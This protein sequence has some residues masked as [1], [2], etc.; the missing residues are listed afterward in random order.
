MV[1]STKS[2]LS[3]PM[4]VAGADSFQPK[5][6]WIDGDRTNGLNKG[7]TARM[8]DFGGASSGNSFVPTSGQ[9]LCAPPHSWFFNYE[10]D[11]DGNV[12]TPTKRSRVEYKKRHFRTF[13]GKIIASSDPSHSAK[14]LCE[15]AMSWSPDFVSFADGLFCDMSSKKLWPL[16]SAETVKNCFDWVSKTLIGGGSWKRATTYTNVTVWE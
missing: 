4:A 10:F 15:S 14:A 3:F 6:G 8:S 16:C 12:I 11:N 1:S 9:G 13:D 7:I 5:C 2:V